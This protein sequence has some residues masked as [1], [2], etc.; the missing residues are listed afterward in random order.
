MQSPAFIHFKVRFFAVL[1]T[2]LLYYAY[3]VDEGKLKWPFHEKN[4]TMI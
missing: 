2:E 4:K 1:N 3:E